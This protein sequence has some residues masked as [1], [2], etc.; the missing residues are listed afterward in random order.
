MREK[1][2]C[3][4]EDFI[5]N[6]GGQKK[7]AQHFSRTQRKEL[8]TQNPVTISSKN[9]EKVKAFSDEGKQREFIS[10]QPYLKKKKLKQVH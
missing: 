10:S 1:T 5:R 4:M 9:E 6:H 7:V 3:M 2:M 8:S